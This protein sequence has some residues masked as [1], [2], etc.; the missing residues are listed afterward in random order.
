MRSLLVA[1]LLITGCSVAAPIDTP[2]VIHVT[3]PSQSS[4]VAFNYQYPPGV[5]PY[6]QL[7]H[8]V[9]KLAGLPKYLLIEVGYIESRY[10]PDIIECK[11]KSPK[12]AEGIM[13]IMPEFHPKVDPC[14]SHDAIIYA[15]AY[16][17]RLYKRFG[18]WYYALAAY[19]WGQGNVAKHIRG[20]KAMPFTVDRY[21]MTILSNIGFVLV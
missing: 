3:S 12:G 11:I 20:E 10:R 9:E 2:G 16:L 1:L 13:Q 7:I 19:N 15:G 18:S 6:Y 8:N 5:R 14:N 4:P 21:A 17:Q